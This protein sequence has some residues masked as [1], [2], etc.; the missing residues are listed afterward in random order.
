[1]SASEAEGYHRIGW[2][3]I[4][5][6]VGVAWVVSPVIYE[7]RRLL[8]DFHRRLTGRFV[9]AWYLG[10]FLVLLVWLFTR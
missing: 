9:V 10:P 4:V 1:M 8:G 3:L 2:T 7:T 6:M 5:L